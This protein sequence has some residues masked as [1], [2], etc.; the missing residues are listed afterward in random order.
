MTGTGTATWSVRGRAE[1][2]VVG[3]P[4]ALEQRVDTLERRLRTMATE[5]EHA[6]RRAVEKA[7]AHVSEV[8][9]DVQARARRDVGEVRDVLLL[10][11]EPNWQ[12]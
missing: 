6:E 12:M 10:V 4:P 2:D 5:V 3:G 1:A 8:S 7:R 9:L 11:T